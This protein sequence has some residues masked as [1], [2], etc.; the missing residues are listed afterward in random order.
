MTLDKAIEILTLM[1]NPEFKG[2]TEDIL[3]ARQLGIKALRAWQRI[4]IRATSQHLWK[5]P[6]E[7]AE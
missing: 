5:L 1:D 3:A 2:H 7:T 4:R 6:G